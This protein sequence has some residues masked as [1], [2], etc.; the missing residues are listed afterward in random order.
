MSRNVGAL[1][2]GGLLLSACSS[3]S[4]PA[5]ITLPTLT[6]TPTPTAT[7]KLGG[8]HVGA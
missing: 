1:C 6:A 3:G 5:P 8:G 7:V 4:D 2:L